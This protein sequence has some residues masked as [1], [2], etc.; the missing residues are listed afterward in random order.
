MFHISEPYSK[1]SY[2][3]RCVNS[4]VAVSLRLERQQAVDPL[5]VLSQRLNALVKADHDRWIKIIKNAGI[6]IE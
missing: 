6:R 1:I 5:E 3:R 2:G 4:R